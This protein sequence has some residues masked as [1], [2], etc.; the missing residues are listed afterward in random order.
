V[1]GRL[2]RAGWGFAQSGF[3]A[4]VLDAHGEE[5]AGHVFVSPSLA[6]HWPALDA[7]EGA[8]YL[9]MPTRAILTDGAQVEAWVYALAEAKR[10]P[11]SKH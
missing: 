5:I 9:R 7:F 8:D 4:L 10:P 2:V 3:P 1:R 6:E 11:S